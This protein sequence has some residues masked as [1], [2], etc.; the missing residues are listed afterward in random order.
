M[1]GSDI[2]Q[3][4]KEV[5]VVNSSYF[6][7]ADHPD[8]I[9]YD[10]MHDH[11]GSVVINYKGPG[12]FVIPEVCFGR[13]SYPELVPGCP[14]CYWIDSRLGGVGPF[15]GAI[16]GTGGGFITNFIRFGN[17]VVAATLF[18]LQG[19]DPYDLKEVKYMLQFAP[20]QRQHHP[21]VE[22]FPRT[23]SF[24]GY[25]SVYND[26]PPLTISQA[27]LLFDDI[28]TTVRDF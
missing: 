10:A 21:D 27:D 17:D 2:G 14:P 25:F 26:F 23:F 28:E 12:G 9:D 19:R 22:Q 15:R 16:K 3:E 8:G 24:I 11:E 5:S 6:L 20:G 1:I 7:G 13:A 4:D 18:R